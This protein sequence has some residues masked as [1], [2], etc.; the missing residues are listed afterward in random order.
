M[1]TDFHARCA[2]TDDVKTA[3]IKR[4]EKHKLRLV[5]R[6]KFIERKQENSNLS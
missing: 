6:I 2:T 4:L 1:V 3:L 5:L